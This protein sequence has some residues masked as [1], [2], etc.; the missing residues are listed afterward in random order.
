MSLS[1]SYKNLLLQNINKEIEI[2]N[3]MDVT[4][5]AY[6]IQNIGFKCIRCGKCCRESCADNSV[7]LLQVDINRIKNMDYSI[8]N[9]FS[10]FIPLEIKTALSN[11]DVESIRSYLDNDGNIHVFGWMLNKKINGDCLFLQSN[12]SYKCSI[13]QSRPYIC[14][15]YPFY[16]E[17]GKLCFSECEGI[18]FTISFEDS[19]IIANLL[20]E[21]Y[22]HELYELYL[23][24]DKY[25]PFSTFKEK[26][27]IFLEKFKK[28]KICYIIHDC[29]GFH[30]RK[31]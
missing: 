8:N 9:F 1:L 18:G 17:N 12:E 24:Y 15:T 3:K 5:L 21:R 29:Q 30:Y 11:D 4:P 2:A 22:K 13:Y 6:S 28:E 23:C 10:P 26:E 25:E 7:L 31:I 16:L 14:S 19:I 27:S 20:L